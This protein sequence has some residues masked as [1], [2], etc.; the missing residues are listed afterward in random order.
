MPH[1]VYTETTV[2]GGF[3]VYVR[4]TLCKPERDVGYEGGIE[5]IQ[6]MTSTGKPAPF[7]EAKMTPRDWEKVEMALCDEC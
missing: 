7:I 1:H 5:D 2:C 4:G 6:I 3:P